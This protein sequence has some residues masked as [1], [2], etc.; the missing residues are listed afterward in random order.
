MLWLLIALA[1]LTNVIPVWRRYQVVRLRLTAAP[2][3]WNIVPARLSFKKNRSPYLPIARNTATLHLKRG[4]ISRIWLVLVIFNLIAIPVLT[5]LT[6]LVYNRI[7]IDR[8]S[9]PVY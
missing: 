2:W 4:P 6:G 8:I 1:I 7:V 9:P 3:A 5:V